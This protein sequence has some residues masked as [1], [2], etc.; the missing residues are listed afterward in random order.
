[1]K[2]FRIG[3]ITGL[4][5]FALFGGVI[6]TNLPGNQVT[7]YAKTTKKVKKAKKPR[8]ERPSENKPYPNLKVHKHVYLQVSLKKQR[9]YVMS[10]H[11]K[12]LYTM[13]CSTGKKSTPTPKG[14]FHIQNRGKHFV[15]ANYWTSFKGWGIYMFH[16]VVIN[17]QGHYIKSEA[18]KLGH[19]A[20]HGCIRMPI[21]DAHWIN[22]HIPAKTKVIIK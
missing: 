4:A 11:H 22:S 21:P 8:W 6:G 2:K 12:V 9:V 10:K 5:I 3:L 13:I 19:R 17:S 15:G 16:S 1:M 20:S 7:A 18:K 14:T